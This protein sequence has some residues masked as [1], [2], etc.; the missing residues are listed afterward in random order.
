MHH[1]LSNYSCFKFEILLKQNVKQFYSTLLIMLRFTIALLK[2]IF[3]VLLKF[4][5]LKLFT[6]QYLLYC[7]NILLM[8]RIPLE[9]LNQS[10]IVPKFSQKKKRKSQVCPVLY[11]P[12]TLSLSLLSNRPTRR[13]GSPGLSSI[14]AST[15]HV[16]SYNVLCGNY[17]RQIIL[18]K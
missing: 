10:S 18:R 15:E 11:L 4:T 7:N 17:L 16:G 1:Q 8:N 3:I 14:R 6:Y 9:S 12:I 5:K 2:Y 13:A